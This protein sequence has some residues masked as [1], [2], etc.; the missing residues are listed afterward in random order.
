MKNLQV[1]DTLLNIQQMVLVTG[2]SAHTLRYYERA[3][4]MK[5]HVTRDDANGYRY[6]TQQDVSW[7]QFIKCL[8]STGMP[9]RDVQRYTELLRQGDATAAARMQLLKQHRLHIEQH[10]REVEQHLSAINIKIERYEELN[11]Q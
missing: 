8:R 2:L 5:Q 6:Y 1:M 11:S 7:V 9:I 4:L 3:G 10:L